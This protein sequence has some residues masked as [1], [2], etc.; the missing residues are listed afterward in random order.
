MGKRGGGGGGG[1]GFIQSKAMNGG[2]TADMRY[3]SLL[4]YN[5]RNLLLRILNLL[6]WH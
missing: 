4:R 6:A 2:L 5:Y 3:D 1:G